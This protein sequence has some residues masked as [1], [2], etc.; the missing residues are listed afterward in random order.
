MSDAQDHFKDTQ[1]A[2]M[3]GVNPVTVRQWRVKNKRAGCIRYG[4]PYEIHNGEVIYPKGAF[5]AW[6][7]SRTVIGGVPQV[8]LPVSANL[9]LIEQALG[10]A[11]QEAAVPAA[12]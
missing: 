4:P 8:N 3:L 7:Q 5:R 10:N 12:R 1:I 9:E 11:P 2:R 6:C